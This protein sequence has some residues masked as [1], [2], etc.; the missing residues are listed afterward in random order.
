MQSLSRL[1]YHSFFQP[2][3]LL[4]I[5]YTQFI[6]QISLQ[7]QI[8]FPNQNSPEQSV[9]NYTLMRLDNCSILPL[10]NISAAFGFI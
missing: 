4:A 9:T 2:L 10:R 6:S 5:A 3:K 8:P 7:L 1:Y